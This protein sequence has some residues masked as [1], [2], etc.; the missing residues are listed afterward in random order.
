M[1][2]KR[3]EETSGSRNVWGADLPRSVSPGGTGGSETGREVGLS[4]LLTGKGRRQAAAA[5]GRPCR[6]DEMMSVL[7]PPLAGSLPH[8]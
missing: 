8:S 7:V 4:Y 2:H 5:G 1:L 6:K 3:Q